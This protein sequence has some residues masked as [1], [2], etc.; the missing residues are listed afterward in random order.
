MNRFELKLAR[1]ILA[2]NQHEM[3][4]E[5]DVTNQYISY[6]ENDKRTIRKETILA[7]ECLLRRAKKLKQFEE[8][9]LLI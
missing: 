6:L 8:Q 1:Q 9:R 5:L 4:K 7:V 3:S 2:L